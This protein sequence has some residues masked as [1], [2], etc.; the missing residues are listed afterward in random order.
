MLFEFVGLLDAV[1]VALC[2]HEKNVLLFDFELA[3]HKYRG[4]DAGS[5]PRDGNASSFANVLFNIGK[6]NVSIY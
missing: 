5:V 4:I 1:W 3:P 6:S 2:H